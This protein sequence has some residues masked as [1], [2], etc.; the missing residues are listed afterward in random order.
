M[1]FQEEQNL[2]T[3][4]LELKILKQKNIIKDKEIKNLKE[5]NKFNNQTIQDLDNGNYKEKYIDSSKELKHMDKKLKVLND[6]EVKYDSSL[7]EIEYLKKK[8]VNLEQA[9]EMLKNNSKTN[10]S[11]SSKPSSTNGFKMVIQNNRVKSGKKPGRDKGHAFAVPK[12]ALNPTIVIKV[13]T[14][15]KCDCGGCITPDKK[16][17]RQLIGLKVIADVT[18]YVGYVG[19]C[20]CG[21]EYYP[22]FPK[23]INQPIQ[24]KDSLKSLMVY[25]NTYCNTSDRV[26]SELISFLT[27]NDINIA[28]ATVLN[29]VKEFSEKSEVTLADIKKKTVISSVLC[30]DETPI[31]I[32]GKQ[33]SALGVFTEDVSLVEAHINR[34]MEEFIAMGILNIYTGISCHDHN[35]IHK[36][37]ILSIQ[38]ECNAHPIRTAKGIYEV[39]KHE[40]IQKWISVMYKAKK[41]KEDAQSFNLDRLTGIEIAEIKNEYLKVLDEWD[42]EYLNLATGKDP[43]YFTK[44][45]CLKDR[46]R[47]FVNDHLRFLTDFRVPFTNNLSERG[48]R[49]LKT[50]LKIIGCFRTMSGAKDYCNAK[51][52]IDTCKKQKV[53][54]GK[55]MISIMC[56]EPKIFDFQKEIKS[57]ETA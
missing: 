38:S 33:C 13:N 16:I 29:S 12:F 50:K 57:S 14:T 31:N 7:V 46:L 35:F 18:E 22:K 3:L 26:V 56:G 2:K 5:R 20:E 9:L 36:S 6:I 39:H 34:T 8:V 15:E 54:I 30:N 25:L 48:L 45:R 11:N 41:M 4:T 1:T 24:Y 53:N 40:S 37:F 49:P 44:N 17:K 47:E 23:D 51:S 10:S 21:K 55:A 32:N 43:K 28:P 19:K 42:I 52:I 27:N